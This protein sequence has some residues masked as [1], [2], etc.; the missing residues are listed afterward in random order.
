MDMR[1]CAGAGAEPRLIAGIVQLKN[2]ARR[3]PGVVLVVLS[4]IFGVIGLAYFDALLTYS[5]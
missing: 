1:P 2:P 4:I 5:Y 3:T